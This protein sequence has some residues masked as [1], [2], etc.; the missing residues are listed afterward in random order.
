MHLV[1]T[2]GRIFIKPIPRFLLVPRF[3]SDHLSCLPGCACTWR[4]ASSAGYAPVSDGICNR[5]RLW[6]SALGFL[7]SYAALVSHESDFV[8]ARNKQLIPTEVTWSDW[9]ILVEQILATD[10]IYHDIHAR[11]IYGEL[12]LS[13]LNKVYSLT[14]RPF[15]RGYMSQRHHYSDFF[16]ENLSWLAAATVYIVVV[17][18]AMQVGL[19]TNLLAENHVFQSASYGFVAFAILGPLIALGLITLEFCRIFLNNWI[20]TVAYKKARL[21]TIHA[22]QGA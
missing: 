17:L 18:T 20:A 1:W 22:G 14:Q 12:R 15:L 9:T 10:H 11:F 6:K 2:A 19:S 8:I 4:L 16:Q 5:R 21:Q 13:R 3:W 7:F